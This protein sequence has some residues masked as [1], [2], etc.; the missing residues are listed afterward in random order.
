MEFKIIH[1]K[2]IEGKFS[3][4]GLSWSLALICIL[5]SC[6][7]TLSS[8]QKYEQMKECRDQWRYYALS[9]TIGVEVLF[10]QEKRRLDLMRYPNLII[11]RQLENGDTIALLDKSSEMNVEV[12]STIYAAPGAWS[13]S[14]KE[15]L[16]PLFTV[17]GE[18]QLKLFCSTRRV[19]YCSV[20]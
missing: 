13:N 16:K 19:Y 1:M 12:G 6:V 8:T 11:G 5:S 14:E 4:V 7:S 3:K 2:M 9:D 10:F 18:E 15:I 17:Q 20:M